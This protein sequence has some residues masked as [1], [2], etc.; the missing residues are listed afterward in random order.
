MRLQ[1]RRLRS[2]LPEASLRHR[3][4]RPRPRST[5]SRSGPPRK[6]SAD[7]QSRTP[8]RLVRNMRPGAPLHRRSVQPGLRCTALL[9]RLLP[10]HRPEFGTAL[11]RCMPVGRTAL[12]RL[13]MQAHT[14]AGPRRTLRP[15]TALLH[16]CTGVERILSPLP[17]RLVLDSS[18]RKRE[19][20]KSFRTEPADPDRSALEPARTGADKLRSPDTVIELHRTWVDIGP[21][22]AAVT[23]DTVLLGPCTVAGTPVPGKLWAVPG[24]AGSLRRTVWAAVLLRNQAS[25]EPPADPDTAVVPRTA[26]LPPRTK[27]RTGYPLPGCR[28]TAARR[29]RVREAHPRNSKLGRFR[30]SSGADSRKLGYFRTI[31]PGPPD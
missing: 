24:T 2:R 14:A 10:M 9:D 27:W 21:P 5:V 29:C 26:A 18:L 7:T 6:R 16:R 17:H 11:L 8:R 15:G 23:A 12:P 3:R 4:S 22:L 20:H 28:C 13:N 31:T 30:K 1:E 19:A 25:R